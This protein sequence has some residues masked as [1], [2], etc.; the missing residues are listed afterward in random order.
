MDRWRVRALGGWELGRPATGNVALDPDLTPSTKTHSRAVEILKQTRSP[1]AGQHGE[2]RCHIEGLCTSGA[3]EEPQTRGTWMT[4]GYRKPM[5]QSQKGTESGGRTHIPSRSSACSGRRSSCMAL[6][7][8]GTSAFTWLLFV[9]RSLA[10]LS[11][12]VSDSRTPWS[13]P[14]A[15]SSWDRSTGHLICCT[16]RD[17]LAICLSHLRLSV[18]T[19]VPTWR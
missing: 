18:L 19:Y 15:S 14:S 9:R 2:S 7:E 12:L 16:C 17:P 6:T 10:V 1:P 5:N 13:C 11:K 3:G 4:V 8:P